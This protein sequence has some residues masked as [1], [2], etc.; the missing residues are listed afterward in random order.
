VVI[1]QQHTHIAITKAIDGELATADGIEQFS[2]GRGVGIQRSYPT[3]VAVG[4]LAQFGS[5]FAH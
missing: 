4:R 2:V 3:P 1:E 5:Q